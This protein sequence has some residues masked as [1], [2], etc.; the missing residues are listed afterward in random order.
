MKYVY[1]TPIIFAL[2]GCVTAQQGPTKIW[3]RAD[4]KPVAQGQYQ[5]DSTICIGETQKSAVGMPPIYY[6]GL[7]GAISASII[8][9]QREAALVQVAEGCMAQR[10]YLHVL[11]PPSKAPA[12]PA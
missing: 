11:A 3:V 1:L 5:I 7:A 9:D 8:Q 6:Q 2:A 12:H 10:G 4:G